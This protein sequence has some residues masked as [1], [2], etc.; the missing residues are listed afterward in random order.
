M[1]ETSL[2]HVALLVPSVE[3]SAKVLESRGI[4]SEKPEVFESEGTKEVYV[5]SYDNQS[6]LLLL[7]EASFLESPK[8]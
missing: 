1:I 8:G 5:G 6:A 2:S 7:L 4:K 3:D